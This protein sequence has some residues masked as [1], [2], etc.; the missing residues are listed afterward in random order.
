MQ[1]YLGAF[2]FG[3][4]KPHNSNTWVMPIEVGTLSIFTPFNFTVSLS[5]RNKGHTNIKG[6]TVN[7]CSVCLNTQSKMNN[8]STHT[9]IIQYTLDS[10]FRNATVITQHETSPLPPCFAIL[11]SLC[12]Q[13]MSPK[14]SHT[15]PTTD[16]PY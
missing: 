3:E 14:F 13:G 12:H 1:N 9:L 10:Q 5:S 11:V 15:L 6:F 16:T 2:Y 4:F 7:E 8:L